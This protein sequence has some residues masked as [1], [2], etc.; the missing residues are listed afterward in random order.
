MGLERLVSVLQGKTSNYDTD[1]FTPLLHAIHQVSTLTGT[2]S[3]SGRHGDVCATFSEVGGG[4]VRRQSGGG[5]S[6]G[7]GLPSRG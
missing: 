6:G 5:A 4:A 3:R 2:P 7:P 1:L